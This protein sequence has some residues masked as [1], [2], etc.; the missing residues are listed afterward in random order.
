M[1]LTHLLGLAWLL[2][3]TAG[4]SWLWP[5]VVPA[6]AGPGEPLFHTGFPLGGEVRIDGALCSLLTLG[7]DATRSVSPPGALDGAVTLEEACQEQPPDG[8]GRS[9][10]PARLV[11]VDTT[12]GSASGWLFGLRSATGLVVAFSGLGMPADGWV[13]ARFAEVAARRGLAT[14]A[15]VR[16]E[17]PRPMVFDPLREARRGVEAARQVLGACRLAAPASLAFVGISLGGLEALLANREA[18]AAGLA[19]RAAVLDPILDPALAAATL[20]GF[21]HPLAV[22]AVQGFFRR[23]LA[24]RYQEPAATTF[25]EV[26]A[27]TASHPGALTDLALDAPSHWLCQAGGAGYAVFLSDTDPALGDAQRGFATACGFPL[28]RAQAP[29]HAPL[30]CRLAL[31]SDLLEFP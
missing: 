29:G 16:D 31:F 25:R 5:T 6:G 3:G 28:R 2:A 9:G 23:L 10:R 19:T 24:G 4:C 14:F 15:L 18:R 12:L 8:I 1:R 13:N 7:P 26:L 27:R 22:D 30:A 11:R 20:D 21:Q 17:S